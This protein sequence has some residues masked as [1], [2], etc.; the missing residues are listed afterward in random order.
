MADPYINPNQAVVRGGDVD[1]AGENT[2]HT[3]PGKVVK[4]KLVSSSAGSP[5]KKAPAGTGQ[6]SATAKKAEPEPK[7]E[8]SKDDAPKPHD[9]KAEWVDFAVSQGLNREEAE[10]LTKNELVELYGD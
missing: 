2:G 3:A 5:S 6:L 10:G 4:G 1:V 8:E 7:A 9:T